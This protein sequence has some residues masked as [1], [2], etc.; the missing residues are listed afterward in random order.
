[1]QAEEEDES[2]LIR[3]LRGEL[4]VKARLICHCHKNTAILLMIFM[5]L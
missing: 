1:M 5:N 4:E 2:R 3:R